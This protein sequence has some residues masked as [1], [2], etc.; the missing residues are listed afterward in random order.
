MVRP[1][2]RELLRAAVVG[3]AAALVVG[4]LGL[5]TP[6]FTDYEAEAEPA[7]NALRD[8]DVGRFLELA[9][10]YGGS[11]LERAPFA[12]VPGL[13]GGG[14]DAVFRAMAVPC[15]LAGVVLGVALFALARRSGAR[16]GAWAVL[17]LTAANPLSLRALEVGHPEELLVGALAVGAALV[18]A[19]GRAGWAGLLLGLAV[20]GKP[21]AAL[22]AVPVLALL[23]GPRQ[24]IRASVV[25]AGAG[26]AVLL[27]FLLAGAGAVHGAAEVASTSGAIFQPWQALWF[28][29][30][31]GTVVTGLYGEKP[32]FRAAPGWA[33][34]VS[35]PLVV[36]AGLGLAIA[37]AVAARRRRAPWHD[38]LLLLA[39]VLLLRCLLDTWNTSYYAVPFLLALLAWEAAARGGVPALTAASTAL[40]WISFETLPRLVPPD[41][42][43]AFYLAW[44]LPL[45][46]SLS[47]RAVAGRWPTT[48]SSLDSVLSTSQPDGVTATRSSIRTPTAPGT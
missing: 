34:Q 5:L 46:A 47:W 33:A 20:A 27:P 24:M 13:W 40:C 48:R 12:L 19:R 17:L 14:G 2:A 39:A 35:H 41:A 10:T 22:A 31:H 7:L 26:G 3:S 42:Q 29:G 6:A 44:A 37:G 4:R 15:L 11:L 9:P 38:G 16:A 28:V 32:G 36:V 25:A 8:G 18:A 1:S 45:A 30:D 21:W 23:P 43:A